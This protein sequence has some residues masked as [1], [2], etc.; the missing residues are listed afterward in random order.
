MYY[1]PSYIDDVAEGF[2]R[3]ATYPERTGRIYHV[4]GPR[5]YTIRE[6]VGTI[7]S[8]LGVPAPRWHVPLA[9]LFAMA[10]VC[11]VTC[12]ALRI[13]PVLYRRR[14]AFFRDNRAFVIER[15]RR[16]L[17]YSPA[18]ELAEGMRRTVTWL[19]QQRLL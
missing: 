11:E 7:A 12:R 2:E 13:E 5:Y 4:A 10:T 14:L 19:R 8:V 3:A 6:Y 15:A 18:I 16:E 17:S 9:P 1:H